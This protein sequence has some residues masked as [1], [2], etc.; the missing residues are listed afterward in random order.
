[1]AFMDTNP[2]A[3]GHVLI[4]AKRH[5]PSLSSVPA[6]TGSRVFV[7]GQAVAAAIRRSGVRC[8]GIT[9]FVADGRAAFQDVFHFHLHVFPRFVGDTFRIEADWSVHPAR[10]ELDRTAGLIRAALHDASA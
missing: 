8:E 7:V 9:L 6:T 5:H 4:I 2:V 1:M 3:T 10:E